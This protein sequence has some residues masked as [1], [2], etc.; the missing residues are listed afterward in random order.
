VWCHRQGSEWKVRHSPGVGG[1]LVGPMGGMRERTGL[2][3]GAYWVGVV[4]SSSE[5][6]LLR[7]RGGRGVSSGGYGECNGGRGCH[8]IRQIT[9]G[10]LRWAD[11]L[12]GSRFVDDVRGEVV[13]VGA[14]LLIFLADLRELGVDGV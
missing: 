13:D 12:M 8:T 6:A 3:A 2:R 1:G 5:D 14:K 4:L 7:G 10:G 11:V 9:Q